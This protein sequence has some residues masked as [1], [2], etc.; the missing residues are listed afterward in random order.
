MTTY[1]YDFELSS[2]EV[3]LL[4]E[5]FSK[6]IK[7]DIRQAH[8]AEALKVIGEGYS[9]SEGNYKLVNV[10]T[11]AMCQIDAC[12]NNYGINLDPRLKSTLTSTSSGCF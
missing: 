7:S 1:R 10:S 11:G 4:L 3:A 12:L 2:S 9:L 6:M 8:V 5:Y